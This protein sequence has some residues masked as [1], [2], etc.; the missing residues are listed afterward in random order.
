MLD[1]WIVLD[2]RLLISVWRHIYTPFQAGIVVFGM[3]TPEGQ[4]NSIASS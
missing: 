4:H 2:M 3:S 1:L